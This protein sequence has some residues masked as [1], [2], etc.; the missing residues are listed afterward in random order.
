MSYDH[1]SV[2]E[3]LVDARRKVPPR[4]AEPAPTPMSQLE[5]RRFDAEFARLTA[6]DLG[7]PMPGEGSSRFLEPLD[8]A[9]VMAGPPSDDSEWLVEPFLARGRVHSLVARR[10]VGKSLFALDLAARLSTGEPFLRSPSRQPVTV[11]YVDQ[12]MSRADLFER[13][14]D[15]GYDLENPVFPR[16]ARN[17]HY[18]QLVDLPPLDTQAGGSAL[19]G[20]VVDCGATVVILD[21]VSRIVEGPENDSDTFRRFHAHSLV[22]LRRLGAT[23]LLVDHLG[24]DG[25]KGPR[26]SSAKGDSVD[27]EWQLARGSGGAFDLLRGKSRVPWVPERFAV[28]LEDQGSR[29][30]FSTEMVSAPPWL[31]AFADALDRAGLPTDA[32]VQ[33]TLDAIARVNGGGVRTSRA[34]EVRR[35]RLSRSVSQRRETEPATATR[36][37]TGNGATADQQ[38][39]SQ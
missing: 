13:L 22:R 14:T 3:M 10:G 12:E 1:P 27:V 30:G 5:R 32:T 6:L 35:F 21:T 7:A 37:R 25:T 17:L 19:E 2:V 18:Y 23:V 24:K 34:G 29:V 38:K 31:M 9:A 4:Q 20:L 39:R 15:F 33:Q 36:Q 11:I 26:G 8:L 28:F 16:L